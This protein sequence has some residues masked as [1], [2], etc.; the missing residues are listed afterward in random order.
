MHTVYDWVTIAIFA[1]LL[2][3]FL[4]RSSDEAPRDKLVHYLI[5]G[6]GC[7]TVNYLGNEGMHLLAVLGLAGVLAFIQL[8]LRPLG[9]NAR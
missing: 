6:A 3:L 8:T 7:A 9:A 5:A 4:H 1:G 2:V